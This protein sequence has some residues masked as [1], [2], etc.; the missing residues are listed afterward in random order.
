MP[1]VLGFITL[2]V[3]IGVATGD[4]L[5]QLTH[6]TAR[7]V[8]DLTVLHDALLGKALRISE[9]AV[10][11]EKHLHYVRGIDAAIDDVR[12]GSAQMAFLVKPTSIQQVADISFGGGVM[13]QKSTDFYPKLLSGI[14][15]Y[16]LG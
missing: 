4:K 1:R 7:G 12:K 15:M 3:V 5:Y 11:N 14:A 2:A 8:L 10:R 13:P 6:R 9:E 16:R